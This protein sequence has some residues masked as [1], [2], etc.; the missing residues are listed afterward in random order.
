MTILLSNIDLIPACHITASSLRDLIQV[1][2][3]KILAD[4]ALS[5]YTFRQKRID[6][7]H[8]DQGCRADK[9]GPDRGQR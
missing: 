6:P 2:P 3:E 4:V 7:W 1:L 5:V 8:S 9:V